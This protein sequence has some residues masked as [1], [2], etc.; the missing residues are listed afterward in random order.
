MAIDCLLLTHPHT[1]EL[2]FRSYSF[3]DDTPFN[4]LQR[5]NYYSL[6]LLTQGSGEIRANFATYLF[7]GSTLC[8][9]GPYQPYT[10]QASTAVAGLVLDFHA[11]F[12]C[13]YRHQQEVASNGILFNTIFEPPFFPVTT[14]AVRE[15]AAL[16]AVMQ[17]EVRRQ[18]VAQ[19][20]S[21]VLYLK[22]F[23]LKAIRIRTAQPA[24]GTEQNPSGREPWLL[25]Q[26]QDAINTHYRHLHTAG[27]YADLL[28]VPARSL[29]RLVKSHYQKTLSQLITERINMEAK[30][31][32]YLTSQSVKA[33]AFA[34]GFGDEYYFSRFFKKNTAVSPQFFRESVGFAKAEES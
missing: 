15:F 1:G 2:A 9:F 6:I 31:E 13:I 17:E 27:E 22:L 34:L 23:L 8:C 29:T 20:E 18:E 24:L 19:Q 3:S 5:N 12:F 26:L 32:L 7:A 14:E 28:R 33:I 25:Q 30:R 11:D 16:A 21:I 4:Y 10:I